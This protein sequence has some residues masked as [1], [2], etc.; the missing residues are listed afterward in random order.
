MKHKINNSRRGVIFFVLVLMLPVLL[1]FGALAI[2]IGLIVNMRARLQAGV[3]AAALACVDDTTFTQN[4]LDDIAK[5][6]LEYNTIRSGTLEITTEVG[7][8]DDVSNQFTTNY[9]NI[10]A[11]RVTAEQKD[12][13]LL[14]A[15]FI[16]HQYTNITTTATAAALIIE[17]EGEEIGAMALDQRA[18][19]GA[20]FGGQ[21]LLSSNGTI[22]VN[23]RGSGYDELHNW[24][25]LGYGGY[26]VDTSGLGEIIA[27]RLLVHGGVNTLGS[28]SSF[29]PGGVHPLDAGHE[30]AP[31]PLDDLLIPG[32]EVLNG[33]YGVDLTEK[34]SVK[35]TNN[36]SVTLSPGIYEDISVLGGSITFL[37]GVYILS[38]K[39]PNQGLKI[40][41]ADYVRG[42]GVMFY[43]TGDNYLSPQGPGYY[44]ALDG[45]LE[46]IEGTD[47]IPMAAAGDTDVIYANAEFE[48]T[49][50]DVLFEPVRDPTGVHP[51]DGVLF[52][53]RRRNPNVVKITAGGGEQ[54]HMNG[55][56]YGKWAPFIMAGQATYEGSF[57]AGTIS[58]SGG[59][60]INI[61][62]GGHSL[63]A[64]TDPDRILLSLME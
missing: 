21:G 25:D 4:E 57:V 14:F 10:D 56:F 42:V 20:N 26:A 60:N 51:Y 35:L 54:V 8:W 62:M 39:L 16:G 11:V 23:S 9:S 3:D 7:Y 2:D 15:P 32:A 48:I 46:L 40:T 19:P 37:P 64:P 61:T 52:F 27:D 31:D 17:P 58:L 1:G 59:A 6:Y 50:G 34:G 5:Q 13:N 36:G 44:D 47:M 43:I 53:Q 18:I 41:G 63:I 55:V 22:V 38:P 28:I 24:I 49:G 12:I 33:Y 29:T 45:P 30:I